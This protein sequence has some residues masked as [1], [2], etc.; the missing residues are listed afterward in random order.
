VTVTWTDP[1]V[2]IVGAGPTGLALAIEL[3]MRSVRCLVLERNDRVGHAP[4]A[5]TTHVRTREIMRHWGIADKLAQASP[6]GIDYPSDVHFVTRLAGHSLVRFENAL[7][8]APGRDE[9]YSE[10]GQ[11]IPQYKLE[12]VLKDHADTLPCVRFEF[13]SSFISA[14]QDAAGISV[15]SRSLA[16]EAEHA[17]N[18]KYLIG[19]D[20]PRSAV[21]ESIGAKM[22]G[23]YG[24]SRNYNIIFHAPGLAQAHSHG[25]GS[26]YWQVNA[27]TPSLIGQM[28][29]DDLWYF[30]PTMLR[31][32]VKLSDD[33]ALALIRRATGIDL[34]YRIL[35]SDEW[36]ASR[37]IADRYRLGRAFLAGDACHLHPPFGGF[38]MNMGVADGFDL[39]WKIAADIQ[40]WGGPA[41]LDSYEAERRPVHELVMDEAENNHAILSNQLS[42]DGIED[43]T[44]AGDAVRAEVAA[45]IRG[46]KAKEFYAL[47]VVLG[48][49]YTNSPVIV[50]DGTEADWRMSRDYVP[51]ATTG[52][53]A[54][55]AWLSDDRSLYDLFGMGFTLLVFDRVDAPDIDAAEASARATNTPL[56]V[57]RLPDPALRALYGASRALIRPDQHISWLGNDWPGDHLLNFV[58]G[59]GDSARW[60]QA[61]A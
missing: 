42:R 23:K 30:M 55:H 21:R 7:N 29:A 5:K 36:V 13:G 16:T 58:S 50:R 59:R 34:P 49:R 19:A 39:G 8:C 9:R 56:S 48:L 2:I 35:S 44:P 52:S 32:G 4:R 1:D 46:A 41:L 31:D 53:L 60:A 51:R 61:A 18:A 12:Q 11:W 25:A 57:V 37:L 6:F 20:G 28:D 47:G 17:I 45:V 33:E 14:K 22:S 40:G 27:D 10:H 3:G 26:M 43:T 15:R 24:L 54:P 38:G